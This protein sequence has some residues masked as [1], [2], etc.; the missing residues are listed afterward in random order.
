LKIYFSHG[1]ESGPKG[2]KI[3]KMSALSESMDFS[4][5]SVDYR[6][7]TDPDKRVDKLTNLLNEEKEDYI[8]VGSSMGG[9]VS[10]VAA[11]KTKPKA[12]FLLAPAFFLSA[13][14]VQKYT[15]CPTNT[16]IVHGWSDEIIPFKH[17]IDFASE[18]NCSL[19]LIPG[20]HRL[21][22]SLQEV[23]DLYRNFLHLFR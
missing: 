11:Q 1:K 3:Q 9:Y 13:Y 17:S 23:M 10:A 6:G 12:M 20:D 4:T 16:S 18:F 19:H 2:S 15:S 22:S 21:V 14:G 8:L 5:F 7:M